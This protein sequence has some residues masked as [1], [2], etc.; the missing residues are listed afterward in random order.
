MN[1]DES[2][3]KKISAWIAEGLQLA[4]IQKRLAAELK[5]SLTYMDVRFLVD[6]L[7]LTPKDIERAKPV[8]KSASQTGGVSASSP[9]GP[10]SAAAG[11]TGS[12]SVSV[13]QVARPGAAVSGSVTF[14]DAMN[15]VWYIDEMGRPGLI[16]SQPGYK[17]S[18]A[19]LQ[20][21]QMALEAEL[22]KLGM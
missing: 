15:A 12:V 22:T 4:E 5:L 8:E 18:A 7:K 2:Q 16:P 9:A 14:S 3:K 20:Q 11:G 13:D 10:T 19:D 6:D 21:F 17:P 1:L